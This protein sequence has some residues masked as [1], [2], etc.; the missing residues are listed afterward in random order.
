MVEQLPLSPLILH[1]D[2]FYAYFLP[3]RHP[4]SQFNIWGGYGLETF[5]KDFQLVNKL[6]DNYVWT[7]LDCGDSA[8]QWITSGIHHINRV[9]YLVT[10]KAHNGLVVDFRVQFRARSLTPL[11]LTRQ[12]RKI[13][14]AVAQM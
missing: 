6:D 5:G 2:A 8:D 7:V 11:G 3:Y 1:E 10:K 14:R 13:E 9:C 12:I 4:E